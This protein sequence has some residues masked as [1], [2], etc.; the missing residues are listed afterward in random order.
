MKFYWMLKATNGFFL[1]A[2]TFFDFANFIDDQA[3]EN[4]KET[5]RP[6]EGKSLHQ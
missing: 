2:K 1:R 6:Y 5:Y 3:K 4:G